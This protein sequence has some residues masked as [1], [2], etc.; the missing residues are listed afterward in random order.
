MASAKAWCTLPRRAPAFTSRK[1][2][3]V[4]VF[5][6]RL[7]PDMQ[8]EYLQWAGRMSSLAT[9][10]PG[11]LSHKAFVAQDGERVTVVEFATEQ[12]MQT[13]ARHPEHLAAKK[14][15]RSSFFS[16]FSV[17][18]CQLQRESRFPRQ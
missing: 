4:I 3:I 11:Y 10:T 18:I 17:Q 9:E 8:A 2:M 7:H 5:R 16:E 1:K 6:S 15:G 14:L 12:G 13:W